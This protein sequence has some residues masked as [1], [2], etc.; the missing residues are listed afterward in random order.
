MEDRKIHVKDAELV[1]SKGQNGFADV[2]AGFKK[3]KWINIVTYDIYFNRNQL[4]SKLKQAP[5]NCRI[6]I[7]TNVPSKNGMKNDIQIYLKELKPELQNPNTSVF[8]NWKN[9]SKI[10]MTDSIAYVGSANFSSSSFHEFGVL[11]KDKSSID[12]LNRAVLELCEESEGYY[13]NR[14]QNEYQNALLFK[15]VDQNIIEELLS[16]CVR[17]DKERKEK[18]REVY[19]IEENV[20]HY[21]IDASDIVCLD[22]HAEQE[23]QEY[24]YTLDMNQIKM[25]Q[26]VMY[27][28][29][30][31]YGWEDS[32]KDTSLT[33]AFDQY[34][35][36]SNWKDKDAEIDHIMSK[37][38]KLSKYLKDGLKVLNSIVN[39]CEE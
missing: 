30:E 26:Y 1:Y 21:I 28:G 2:V 12:W 5:P 35:G 10:I 13:S 31:L 7:V 33:K 17:A 27:L 8:F 32:E 39:T 14:I 29:K 23:A 11:I 38:G 25:V 4:L 34:E 18:E 16:I 22:I 36:V 19:G 37:S 3:A 20:R 24:L 9:H 15:D 6:R